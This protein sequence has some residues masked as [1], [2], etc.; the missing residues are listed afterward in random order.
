[1]DCKDID[2]KKLQLMRPL[3]GIPNLV[4]QGSIIAQSLGVWLNIHK[5]T[6]WRTGR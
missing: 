1:L 6:D 2:V 3:I 4:P 5:P